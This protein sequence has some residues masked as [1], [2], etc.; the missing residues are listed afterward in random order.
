MW[1]DVILFD[2][3]LRMRRTDIDNTV[4][5]KRAKSGCLQCSS[6]PG[7]FCGEQSGFPAFI[8]FSVNKQPTRAYSLHP[9]YKKGKMFRLGNQVL[10]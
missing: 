5:E 9:V 6:Y 3:T 7:R 2:V 1:M 10:F 8:V 4:M